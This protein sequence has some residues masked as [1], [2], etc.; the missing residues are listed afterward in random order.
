MRKL[1]LLA[2][3]IVIG[4]LVFLAIFTR[5][6]GKE[7]VSDKP[8]M[9]E[10]I[11]FNT[12]D[13][14]KIAATFY[15]AQNPNGAA[16]ILLH[17]RARNRSDWVAFAAK[18]NGAGFDALAID[19]RGHGESGGVNVNN[20][21][22]SDYQNLILDVKAADSYLKNK[23]ANTKIAI[24]GGSIGANTALNYAVQNPNIVAVVLLSPGLDYKG[25]RTDETSKQINTPVFLATSSDDPQS[26]DGLETW[27]ANIKN[28]D[29]ATFSDAGH[30]TDMFGPHPELAD[31][32]IDWLEK[33][34]VIN[35]SLKAR[36]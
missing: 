23:N 13:S 21:S 31:K 27:K 29:L 18:L 22:D 16:V 4:A 7:G 32:I 34:H 19:F 8:K 6:A 10:N 1:L 9:G 2:I 26:Y 12:S 3:I 24:A 20:F 17:M 33:N 35:L 36:P 15:K 25:V 11:S 14:V 30:G 5:N 28:L